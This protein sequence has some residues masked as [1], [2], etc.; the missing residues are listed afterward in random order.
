[1]NT[2]NVFVKGQ[3]GFEEKLKDIASRFKGKGGGPEAESSV[4]ASKMDIKD[5][6]VWFWSD[7]SDVTNIISRSTKYILEVKDCYETIGMKI[8]K[9]GFR[10]CTYCFK[11]D[12]VSGEEEDG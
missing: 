5:G 3:E 12:S 7:N 10:G 2:K 9:T 4:C 6:Y 8:D 1:M 11:V